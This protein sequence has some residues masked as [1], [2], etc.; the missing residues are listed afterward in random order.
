M[1]RRKVVTTFTSRLHRARYDMAVQDS[2]SYV[3]NV[4]LSDPSIEG[5]LTAPLFVP[6]LE[7]DAR[8][9]HETNQEILKTLPP[10]L[11]GVLRGLSQ[12]LEDASEA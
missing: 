1:I 11:A 9:R 8:G 10:D 7:A 2:N 6:R 5:D 12:A 3:C 4:P